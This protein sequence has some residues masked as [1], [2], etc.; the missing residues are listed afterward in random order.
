M[1][2]FFC[3]YTLNKIGVETLFTEYLLVNFTINYPP[4][5]KK[6]S[7]SAYWSTNTEIV[8]LSLQYDFFF[9]QFFI[10]QWKSM[11]TETV[12]FHYLK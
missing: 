3:P 1:S 9:I 11:V 12:C 2:M 8:F 6:A 7:N 4:P 5:P 10:V